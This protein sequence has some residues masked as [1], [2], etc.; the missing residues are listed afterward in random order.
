MTNIVQTYGKLAAATDSSICDTEKLLVLLRDY[1]V[2][3]KKYDGAH[4]NNNNTYQTYSRYI[5]HFLNWYIDRKGIHASLVGLCKHDLDQYYIQRRSRGDSVKTLNVKL[6]A[7]KNL[8]DCLHYHGFEGV[9]LPVI[10][11]AKIT[12]QVTVTPLGWEQFTLAFE[13]IQDARLKL[14][15]ALGGFGGFRC[16]EIIN[17]NHEDFRNDHM[18]VLGKGQ[19]VRTIPIHDQVRLAYAGYIQDKVRLTGPVFSSSRSNNGLM[20]RKSIHRLFKGWQDKNGFSSG[21]HILR[22]TFATQLL[23]KTGDLALVQ[24]SLGHEDISTTRIYTKV[25]PERVRAAVTS[26]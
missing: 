14:M 2:T 17:L 23:S 6:A 3:E 13:G 1:F 20:A 12:K 7:I 11:R 10:R 15:V 21:T 4:L 19:K 22:H 9:H 8:I 16:S 26:L 18:R 5:R 25:L 24:D